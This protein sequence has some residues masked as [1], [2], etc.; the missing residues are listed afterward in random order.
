MQ[1]RQQP[2]DLRS[3]TAR[4]PRLQGLEFAAAGAAGVLQREGEAER[5]SRRLCGGPAPARAGQCFACAGA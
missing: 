4:S 2:G 1:R 5:V 3:P